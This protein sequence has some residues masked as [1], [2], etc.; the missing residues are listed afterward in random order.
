NGSSA[1]HALRT[2]P[3]DLVS[4]R[5]VGYPE[6][7]CTGMKLATCT[8]PPIKEGMDSRVFY[9]AYNFY[10]VNQYFRSWYSAV[11]GAATLAGFNIDEIVQLV[12]PPND[13]NLIL[14]N[15]LIAPTGTS[16]VAPGLG[17][18]I[19]PAT[20]STK[21]SK[22]PPKRPKPCA[23]GLVLCRKKK[24][25]IIAFPRSGP[26]L[27]PNGG[28]HAIAARTADGGPES[29]S[30]RPPPDRAGPT[31]PRPSRPSW[32][33]LSPSPAR[34][35]STAAHPPPPY[36]TSS[37]TS[38]Y[39]SSKYIIP[40]PPPPALAGHTIHA[41]TPLDTQ[42][43]S[44]RATNDSF[45]AAQPRPTPLSRL[46]S[47]PTRTIGTTFRFDHFAHDSHRAFGSAP[48]SA[49][50]SEKKKIHHG[51]IALRERVRVRVRDRPGSTGG[52]VGVMV[53]AAAGGGLKVL[54]W[55][56]SCTG[57]CGTNGGSSW[58]KGPRR[59]GGWR[60]VGAGDFL[61]VMDALVVYCVPEWICGAGGAVGDV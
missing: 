25:I 49:A 7:D 9:V 55:D 1:T 51:L 3:L 59:N 15:I 61:G 56:M 28:R 40:P 30:R 21:P 26:L 44:A 24:A 5:K 60:I 57:V 27:L 42:P 45:P 54:T 19:A 2:N 58:R 17:F 8:P 53:N 4:L 37:T 50:S 32:R 35:N 43:A 22:A 29:P 13:T 14:N 39:N 16:A 48:H 31:S 38:L 34:R 36:Q 11:G 46:R 18:S 12:N 47:A 20:S 33:P 23:T 52:L 10:A 6:L 41:L